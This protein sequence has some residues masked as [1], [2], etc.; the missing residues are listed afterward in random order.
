MSNGLVP[1]SKEE[2]SVKTVISV[3]LVVTLR[4]F[5]WLL[6]SFCYLTYNGRTLSRPADFLGAFS[7]PGTGIYVLPRFQGLASFAQKSRDLS[8]EITVG[9]TILIFNYY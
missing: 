1:N 9:C 4:F 8:S 7:R 3:L 2:E 6:T 5:F